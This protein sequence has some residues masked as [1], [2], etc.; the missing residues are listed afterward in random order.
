MNEVDKNKVEQ[1]Y[2]IASNFRKY[3]EP[4][5]YL[6]LIGDIDRGHLSEYNL[7]NMIQTKQNK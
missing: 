4:K 2:K 5:F 1:V 6:A 7:E 3:E